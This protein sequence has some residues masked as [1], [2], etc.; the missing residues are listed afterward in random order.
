MNYVV[1]LDSN[2]PI[3]QGGYLPECGE[4]LQDANTRNDI[5]IDLRH[6]TPSSGNEAEKMRMHHFSNKGLKFLTEG[7]AQ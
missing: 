7:R 5:V 2:T 4:Y 1:D 3:F 6:L